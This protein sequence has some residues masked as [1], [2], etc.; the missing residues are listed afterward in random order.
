MSAT[1]LHSSLMPLNDMHGI[2]LVTIPLTQYVENPPRFQQSSPVLSF[3]GDSNML[4]LYK[5]VFI[6]LFI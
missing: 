1:L 2:P 6:E 4:N 5:Y 3:D